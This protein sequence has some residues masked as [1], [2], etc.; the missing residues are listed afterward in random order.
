MNYLNKLKLEKNFNLICTFVLIMLLCYFL[1][2]NKEMFLADVPQDD[3]APST[4]S[5]PDSEEDICVDP[6]DEI[7]KLDCMIDRVEN[8][9]VGLNVK[10]EMIKQKK[11]KNN[12]NEYKFFKS[13]KPIQQ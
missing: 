4:L 2:N 5:P 10:N 9:L 6:K 7:T 8:I 12:E 1:M 3:T 11:R 13:C